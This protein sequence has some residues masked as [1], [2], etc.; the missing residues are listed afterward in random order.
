MQWVPL[1]ETG[2]A[3]VHQVGVLAVESLKAIRDPTNADAV[4]AVGE[5]SSLD[6]L[7]NMKNCMMADMRG[8]NILKHTPVVCD[9][10]LEVSRGLAPST[11]GFRYA[12]YMDRNHFL[13]SGRTA[14]R[15]IADPTLAY[16]MTRYRQCHDFLHAITGCGRTVEEEL[17]VKIFEWRHTGLPLGLLSVVGGAPHLSAT[18]WANLRLYWEWA[19]L[20]APCSRHDQPIIPMYLNVPWEDMLAM[21]YDE[22]MRYTGITPLPVFLESRKKH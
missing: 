22:V 11:F 20:N 13:P 5:L 10:A 21:E 12:A 15:H 14:V 6:A 16:V 2:G 8:R 4:A 17:A 3:L 9:E 1:I 19:T 7:E 18:Q